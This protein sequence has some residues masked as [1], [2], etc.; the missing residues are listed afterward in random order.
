RLYLREHQRNI[1]A[2]ALA[3]ANDLNRVAPQVRRNQRFF[4]SYVSAQAALRAL[5]EAIVIDGNGRL[6][7][8][9]GLS[10][11]L[12]FELGTREFVSEISSSL[13]P[14]NVVILGDGTGDRVRAGI[15]LS[16][17]V[18]A[19]LIVG[20]FVASQVLEHLSRTEGA[21]IQYNQLE[22]SR[23]SLQIKF[24]LVFVVV[25]V[26]LLLASVWIGWSIATQLAT[27]ISHL[28][29]AAE[30]VRKGD[31]TARVNEPDA[32]DEV[33]MLSRAFNRMT[34]QL[35]LQQ[36]GLIEANRELDERRR[37]TET[38]LEGVSAGVIGLDK[39]GCIHLSNASAS[40]LLAAELETEFGKSLTDV[41]P[42]MKGLFDSVRK[43]PDRTA[44]GEVTLM[45]DGKEITL[46]ASIA[47]EQGVEELFGYVVTFDD[48]SELISAQRKAAWA[49]IA[50]RIAHEIK[51][52]L[53]PIQLSAERLKRKYRNEI[54]TDPEI[55]I[56]CT[57][58]IVRQ[59]E[60]IGRMVDEFSAFARMPQPDFKDSDLTALVKEIFFLESNRFPDIDYQ[61][62]VPDESL[63]LRCDRRQVG[64]ALTNILKNASEAVSSALQVEPNDGRKGEIRVKLSED[65]GL[66]FLDIID[67]GKG[68]PPA[69]K[70]RLTEPYVTTRDG[71]TGLG[72]AIAKKVMEDHHG[73]LLMDNNEKHGAF[74]RLTFPHDV[75]EGV[76]ASKQDG[77]SSP[78]ATTA[79]PV[80]TNGV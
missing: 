49:D 12:E 29:G 77:E 70:D 35:E 72:L 23:E 58:T 79:K 54:T 14:G 3:M 67:N 57:D 39:D 1:Q 47:A 40:S 34:S 5:P 16:A 41:I 71:G 4:T 55:F 48:V 28:I 2:D 66:V 37:F 80:V 27:P 44:H 36:A 19:Y 65:D 73:E 17:F 24:L 26:L 20:R 56:A 32:G 51:N 11:S 46:L 31:I 13:Q 10:Y 78:S 33:G 68:L 8:R 6:L 9:S 18:D 25:A 52:P 15:K 30:R 74:I 60:D 61:L 69:L 45:R 22:R 50:R 75:A 59:V 62:D 21:A 7:A 38:V 76:Q 43:R 53:T 42:E 64:R 63:Y